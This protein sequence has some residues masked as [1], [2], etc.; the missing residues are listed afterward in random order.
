VVRERETVLFIVNPISGSGYSKNLASKIDKSLDSNR[1]VSSIIYTQHQGHASS[2]VKEQ[3]AL[4]VKKVFAVGGDGTV[5]EVAKAL[6]NTDATL[7]II[8]IGSGNGLARHLRIPL[9]VSKSINLINRERIALVDYGVIN[10]TPFFCTAGV[11]FDAH[12]GNVFANGKVRGFKN[13]VKSAISEFVKYP[14]QIYTLHDNGFKMQKEAFLITVANASQYGNNAYIAPDADVTD[15]LL[16]VTIISPFP[17]Y[18]APSVGIK[19]FNKKL[20]KS[21]FVE[22]FR[23]RNLEIERQQNDYVHYD[24]EPVMMDKKLRFSVKP[25][26]L[27]IYIP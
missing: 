8:P 7:G 19:L 17:K 20:G 2:I 23:V 22:M 27:K 25:L 10:N 24:G 21:R 14:S 15:G 6:T 13:Y 5:N 26:G 1:Y 3:L 11:G 12:I 16:D 9:N 4:G 18:L